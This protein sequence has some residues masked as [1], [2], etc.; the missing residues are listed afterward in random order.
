MRSFPIRD[1]RPHQPP[2]FGSPPH[3]PSLSARVMR[4]DLRRHG[5]NGKVPK[6]AGCR[7]LYKSRRGRVGYRTRCRFGRRPVSRILQRGRFFTAVQD[8][9]H[10]ATAHS[11]DSSHRGIRIKGEFEK[12]WQDVDR[13]RPLQRPVGD[14]LGERGSSG[15]WHESLGLQSVKPGPVSSRRSMRD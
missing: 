8:M 15:L 7:L 2:R 3:S 13:G 1:N 4:L 9:D 14:P 12:Q 10:H 11:C 6:S 5:G